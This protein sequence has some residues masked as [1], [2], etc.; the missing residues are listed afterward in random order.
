[1]ERL[2]KALKKEAVKADKIVQKKGIDVFA[3][4]NE[5]KP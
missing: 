3:K 1:M 2:R 5:G 4:K